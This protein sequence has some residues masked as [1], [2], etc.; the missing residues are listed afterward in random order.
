ME[1]VCLA[2]DDCQRV[3]VIERALYRIIED[4]VEALNRTP[5]T[6]TSKPLVEG[7]LKLALGAYNSAR[8]LKLKCRAGREVQPS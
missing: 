8:D 4:L 2:D 3:E 1:R 7:A 5:A 6:V